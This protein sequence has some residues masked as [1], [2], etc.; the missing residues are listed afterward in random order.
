VKA[1][2]Y[3]AK[4]ADLT[5]RTQ[6]AESQAEHWKKQWVE[7]EQ[8]KGARMADSLERATLEKKIR[9][10]DRI[11]AGRGNEAIQELLQKMPVVIGLDI[12]FDEQSRIQA[13]NEALERFK[14]T[15]IAAVQSAQMKREKAP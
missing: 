10:I 14:Q 13:E 11:T 3:E 5:K 8:S 4:I 1:K 6:T 15:I 2:E 12:R 9:I 7:S